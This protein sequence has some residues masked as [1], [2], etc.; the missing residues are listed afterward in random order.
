[1]YIAVTG[2]I[3]SGKTYLTE[4]LAQHYG[5]DAYFVK[6]SD[7]PYIGDFYDDMR[8]WAF[9]LQIYFLGRR[10]E[11]MVE[12]ID[13]RLNTIL[14]RTIY[15]DAYIFAANLHDMGLF[16][17]RDYDSYM[18]LFETVVERITPPDVMIYLQTSVPTLIS[19]IQRRGRSYETTIEDDYLERLN[20]K[21]DQW[22][23]GYK[24]KLL[25]VNVDKC[26]FVTDPSQVG[27]IIKDVDKLL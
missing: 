22:I 21:Y 26:D 9:N 19:H 13:S 17:T 25:I 5:W 4:L 15:E 14:D 18:Q 10:L 27:Q 7:N 20:A 1:M 11:Q 23:A 3:G 24:G 6:S 16:D 8:R 2:N 12:I